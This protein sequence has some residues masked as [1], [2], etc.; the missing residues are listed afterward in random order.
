MKAIAAA[1][2]GLVA[3]ASAEAE[4]WLAAG[5]AAP[6]V[7]AALPAVVPI[8]PH[9]TSGELVEHPNGAL[10]PDT[11]LSV[12]AAAADHLNAKAITY[13]TRGPYLG[14]GLGLAGHGIW[15]REAEA[16]PW[17]GYGYGLAV[18]AVGLPVP[19]APLVAH[20]NGAVTPDYTPAQKLAAADHFAK[21]GGRVHALPLL[22]GHA[23]WKR[24]AEAEAEPWLGYG[25]GGY[26]G[27]GLGYAGLG[28]AGAYAAPLAYT[29]APLVHAAPLC[30]NGQHLVNG[31]CKR[32]AEA[33]PEPW[34]GYGYGLPA[35]VAAPLVAHPNGA[36]V[37]ADEPAVVAARADHLNAKALTYATRGPY[38]GYGLGLAGHGIWKREAEAEAKPWYNAYGL[39]YGGA[40]TGYAGLGYAGLGY[41][42]LGYAGLGYGK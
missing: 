10:T 14:Y 20:P 30:V 22:A 34:L 16:E 5:Y 38:L 9:A 26:A 25:L 4:P 8:N 39:G 18:P 17:L 12:K 7:V 2:T 40:Y 31:L 42:G 11:T 41:S 3:A 24:E 1:L 15:K 19:A 32:E 33:D 36:V 28:Y 21:G 35:A 27:L 23:L 13:A 37:P 6:A 29:A